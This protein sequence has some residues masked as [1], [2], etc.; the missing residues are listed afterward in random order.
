MIDKSR[1]VQNTAIYLVPLVI[2][3]LV[4]IATLPVF[5]R[6]LSAE[7]FGAWAL[8][9]SYASVVSGLA[10]AGL[11]V[12]Y[13]RNFFEQRDPQ[14]RCELLYSVMAFTAVTFTVCL[15]FT[16]VFRGAIS[17]WLTGE[18]GYGAVVVWAVGASAVAGVKAYY[19]SFLRNT[20]QASPFAAYMIAERLLSAVIAVVLVAGIG[21]GVIG[22]VAGQLGASLLVLVVMA[23]RFLP[24]NPPVFD[25][26]L[27][28][29]ALKV[30]Y[31]LMPRVLFGVV[32]NNV[33][34]YLIGQVASLGGVG[35]Y[36]IG[37]RVANIAFTYMTALQN[38]FGPRVYA[39]M[40][41]GEATAGTEIGRYLTPFAYASTVLSFAI[42]L[43]SEELLTLLAPASYRDAIPITAILALYF[44]ILFFGKM[45]Q[46]AYARKTHL[47]S[48]IS[49]ASVV[50]NVACG[51]AGIWLLG[52]IGAAWG[53]LVAGVIMTS[54]TFAVGQ[55]CFRIHW[56]TPRMAAIFGL[57]FASAL[58][59]IALRSAGAPYAA[60]L[61]LK[62][63]AVAAFLWLGIR[64]QIVT[65][66]NLRLVR[67]LILRR[68]A[69]TE[70]LTT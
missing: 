11:P 46:I 6:L 66:E 36:S 44:A 18:A 19:M 43:F 61:G 56:E 37:Q 42:A 26:R 21:S 68:S 39:R 20:E 14:R 40:F 22:L 29:D 27:L 28:I 58:T 60:L 10:A 70:T 2:G 38:V 13:E 33:D 4:P 25:W 59:T 55:R 23:A 30:G 17:Q 64:L 51:A 53:A 31:P 63:T 52:T 3:N 49:A 45:P 50:V 34:K 65:A 12:A 5:T 16:F 67:D 69:P 7:D 54:I 32:G 47:L 48:I 15:A 57:L 1:Q 9:G 35:I 24:A 41:S 62:L 8:A